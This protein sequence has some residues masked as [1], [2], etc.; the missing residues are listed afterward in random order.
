MDISY[1]I[2][3]HRLIIIIF[4][5]ITSLGLTEVKVLTAIPHQIIMA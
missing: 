1:E 2:Q 4:I 3:K 5:W